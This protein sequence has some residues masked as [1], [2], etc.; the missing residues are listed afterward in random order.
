MWNRHL[1]AGSA[2]PAS[3]MSA[4]SVTPVTPLLAGPDS[5][6]LCG[7]DYGFDFL[8]FLLMDPLDLLPLLL[9]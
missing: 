8:P 1:A 3:D 5:S 6:L 7:C 4:A 9:R 2:V